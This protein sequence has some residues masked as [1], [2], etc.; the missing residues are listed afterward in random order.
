MGC[1][2]AGATR[3]TIGWLIIGDADCTLAAR[4]MI[5]DARYEGKGF[6]SIEN[7]ILNG[8]ADTALASILRRIHIHRL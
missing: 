8:V 5:P 4:Q 3:V 2:V 6:C 7:P 1:V